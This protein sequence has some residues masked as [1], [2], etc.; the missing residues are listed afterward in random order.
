KRIGRELQLRPEKRLV[1]LEELLAWYGRCE[2]VML[3][4]LGA[5]GG[6]EDEL[7]RAI[8]RERRARARNRR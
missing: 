7:R 3:Y 1:L 4:D 2:P 8:E 5:P 6:G